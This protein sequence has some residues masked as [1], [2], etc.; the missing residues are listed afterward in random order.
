MEHE[1]DGGTKCNWSAQNNLHRVGNGD[2]RFRNQRMN[3]DHADYSIVKIGQN[4]EKSP[5]DLRKF[6]IAYIPIKDHQQPLIYVV[7]VC[8]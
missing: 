4:T 7:K 3:T 8:P 5:G 2:G 6:S 1:G